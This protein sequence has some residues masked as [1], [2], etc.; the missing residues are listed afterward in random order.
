MRYAALERPWLVQQ[1]QFDR[2][3]RRE[4][5]TLLASTTMTAPRTL[6]AQGIGARRIGVLMELAADEPQARSNVAALQR[7]LYK[8][9]WSQGSDLGIDYRWAPDDPVLV[10]K[11]AKELVELQPDV[12]VAHSSPVVATLLGQT[13]NIP[14]VFVS[15]SDP[16]GEGFVA[17]F[18]HPGGNV[19]G[20]TNFESS[21]TGKWVELL[22]DIAP[23]ITRVGFLFNPQTTAGGGSY[24]LRPIDE[25]AS[26]FKVK[27]GMALVHDDD[28]IEAAFAGL[29]SEPG[30]GAVLLPDIFTVAHHLLVVTLAELYRV[31]TVY[32]Y[33]FM[34]ER[35]GLISYGVDVGNLFERAA[36][37]V[38]RI[39]K[40]V[41]PADLPV[42]APTKFELAVNQKTAKA[43]GLTIPPMLLAIA[44]EVIE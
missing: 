26:A 16:I 34:A 29:A 14:I 32:G 8:L 23:E 1:M 44:D 5:I 35:G 7:G 41:K 38:D 3:K 18:A 9:G 22:K 39:L 4:F 10:W 36:T 28:E 43:L 11:Y 13:R 6:A 42:Q 20:F 30:A 19:T 25:A 2:L 37:Y 31:P 21:M 15:I 27:A 24:F 33:R 40:G 12:I 17:S